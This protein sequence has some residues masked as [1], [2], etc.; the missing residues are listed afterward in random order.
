LVVFATGFSNL[1]DSIR[2]TLGPRIANQ[3]GPVWG[4]DEEGEFR[5]AFRETGVRNLW[6][7]VG[8]LPMTRYQSRVLAL[9]LKA[10]VERISLSPYKD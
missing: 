8:F 1:V 5:N 3:V 2:D 7:M 10:L 6:I 4:I 9:R